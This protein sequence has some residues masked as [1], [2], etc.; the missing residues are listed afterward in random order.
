M[1]NDELNILSSKKYPGMQY[2]ILINLLG[3][4]LTLTLWIVY[5]A[6]DKELDYY[7]LFSHYY[8]HFAFPLSFWGVFYGIVFVLNRNIIKDIREQKEI[9]EIHKLIKILED[10]Q[11]SYY[12]EGR[13]SGSAIVLIWV[14][15][16]NLKYITYSKALTPKIGAT[17]KISIAKYS[18]IIIGL[19]E[20]DKID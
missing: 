16:C 13:I 15:D 2:A 9:I 1:T 5:F 11:G 3:I 19:E 18:R 7:N 20:I 10:K 12:V 8:I 4:L 17:Y 6:L 14:F